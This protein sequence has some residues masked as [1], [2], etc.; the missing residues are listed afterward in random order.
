MYICIHTHTSDR[1][2]GGFGLKGVATLTFF[3]YITSWFMLTASGVTP[4]A[5]L[6]LLVR[7][8]SSYQSMRP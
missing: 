5:S 4:K 2:K 6:N 7:A 8:A 3:Q 1:E